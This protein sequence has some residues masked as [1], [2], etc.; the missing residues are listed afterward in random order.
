M[1]VRVA[2]ELKR[3]PAAGLPAASALFVLGRE[4]AGVLEVCARLGLDPSRRIHQLAGGFLVKLDEVTTAA[5]PGATRLRALAADLFVPV[6]AELVPSLLDDEARGLVRDAGLVLL[7]DGRALRFERAEP[8]RLDELVSATVRPRRAWRALP[9]PRPLA[10]RLVEVTREWPEPDE[11]PYRALEDTVRGP[12]PQRPPKRDRRQKGREDEAADLE[13]ERSGTPA[14]R[15]GGETDR[16]RPGIGETIRD[17]IGRAG[18]GARAIGE[19]IHF[20]VGDHSSLVEKLIRELRHGDA[21]RALRHAFPVSP[22]EP[23]NRAVGWGSRLPWS[24]A[25]YNL[26]D[27]LG[28]PPRGQPVG[29]WRAREDLM[30]ALVREYGRLA[31][32]AMRQGDFRRA[33]Y[34]YG[35]LMGDARMAAQ[36]LELGGLHGDAAILYW[37][38]VRDPAAAARAFEAAGEIDR[39]IAL[40]RQV[41]RHE[42]AGDLLRRLGDHQAA[43]AEYDKTV[44]RIRRSLPTNWLE[45]GRVLLAKVRDQDAAIDAYSQGWKG[46]PSINA[47][48]CALELA[49]IQAGQGEIGAIRVLLDEAD[50]FFT[51]IGAAHDAGTFYN[52]LAVIASAAPAL[53]DLAEE[54]RD[55]AMRGL[56]HH[57]RQRIASGHPPLPAVSSLFSE[58]SLWSPAFLRDARFA[59]SAAAERRPARARDI[60]GHTIEPRFLVADGSVSAVCQ[61]AGTGIVFLGFTSGKVVAVQ[62]GRLQVMPL[63]AVGGPVAALTVDDGSIVAALHHTDHRR[64]LST[65]VRLPDGS[66]QARG[67]THL[68]PW[69]A[70]WLT[71][72]LR[73]GATSLVGLGDESEVIILDMPTGIARGRVRLSDFDGPPAAALLCPAGESVHVLTHDGPRWCLLD[74]EGDPIGSHATAW[75][76]VGGGRCPRCTVPLSWQADGEAVKVVGLDK[77]GALHVSQFWVEPQSGCFE[78]LSTRATS[79]EGGFVA[80]TQVGHDR[81]VGVVPGRIDWFSDRTDRLRLI[82]SVPIRDPGLAKVA[83][84]FPSTT[85]EDMLI[86]TADGWLARI[87]SR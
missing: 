45:V 39:A 60:A 24:R 81:V 29:V 40:Y 44:D 21:G 53:A 2:F 77:H 76:P 67:D 31:V 36:A 10:D 54:V 26:R 12:E 19:A 48:A 80:A 41:G 85:P 51:T 4:A 56:A 7:P 18:S 55:R 69:E 70:H 28:K 58:T 25:V 50:A 42:E 66:Y 33:A 22:M 11:D 3:R 62:P 75:Q 86:I 52:R 13:T 84:C 47:T 8:L 71:P 15:P 20:G 37:R 49:R 14:P 16:N 83:A 63:G 57:L 6:D 38:K 72:I 59:A 61:A 87:S 9:R 34:I 73:M 79:T 43:R 65:F 35:K 17:L 23:G 82:R 74:P 32:Q 30:A 78:L 27:L 64:V 1:T 46:R 68:P 5:T